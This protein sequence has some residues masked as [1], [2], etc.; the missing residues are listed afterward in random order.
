MT[1]KNKYFYFNDENYPIEVTDE[2]LDITPYTFS[3]TGE[4]WEQQSL[5]Q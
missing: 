2:K 4:L 5:Y 3:H 1:F